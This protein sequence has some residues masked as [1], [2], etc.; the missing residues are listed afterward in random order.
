MRGAIA[1]LSFL[2]AVCFACG[3]SSSN[4]TEAT[5]PLPPAEPGAPSPNAASE[6]AFDACSCKGI[7]DDAGPGFCNTPRTI[8]IRFCIVDSTCGVHVLKLGAEMTTL[9]RRDIAVR[10]ELDEPMPADA[11][12]LVNVQSP[13]ATLKDEL[14]HGGLQLHAARTWNVE[15]GPLASPETRVPGK[16]RLSADRKAVTITPDPLAAGTWIVESQFGYDRFFGPDV[17]GEGV[18]VH[19]HVGRFALR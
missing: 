1:W 19:S 6:D 2:G 9:D 13:N 4:T 11:D 16:A 5:A 7:P 8:M 15:D 18:A 10:Y 17:C 12:L 14:S 3:S